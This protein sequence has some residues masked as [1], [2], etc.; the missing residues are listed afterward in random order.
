MICLLF[1]V[2]KNEKILSQRYEAAVRTGGF[3]S[4][5]EDGPDNDEEV[6]DPD[7]EELHPFSWQ[8]LLD[9][10]METGEIKKHGVFQMGF[11]FILGVNEKFNF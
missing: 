6:A 2:S 1:L 4:Q 8:N 9:I 3:I 7:S 10:D 5:E 11:F